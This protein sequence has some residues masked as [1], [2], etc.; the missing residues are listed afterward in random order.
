MS[1]SPTRV[2]LDLPLRKLRREPHVLAVAADGQRELVF[3]HDRLN[4][5]CRRIAEHAS[6]ASR[7][8]RELGEALRVSR[9]RHDVDSLAAELVDD[10]LDS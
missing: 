7:S 8:E 4:R 6:H 2:K 3:V 1:A 9:P 5:F 10:G